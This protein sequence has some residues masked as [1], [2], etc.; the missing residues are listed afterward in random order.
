MKILTIETIHKQCTKLKIYNYK[1]LDIIFQTK[2]YIKYYDYTHTHN[3]GTYR[4]P[5][6]LSLSA[7]HHPPGEQ[8][9]QMFSSQDPQGLP[10][11]SYSSIKKFVSLSFFYNLQKI[12]KPFKRQ[13]IEFYQRPSPLN[14]FD[15]SFHGSFFALAF[16]FKSVASDSPHQQR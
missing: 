3:M 10:S 5:P 13:T 14:S 1:L 9:N 2:L 16:I 8:V 7:K 6:S 11:F 4:L 12:S 15:S